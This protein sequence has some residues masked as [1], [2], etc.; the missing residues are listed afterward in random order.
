MSNA[1]RRP[2]HL[3]GP[4]HGDQRISALAERFKLSE[5]AAEQ[6]ARLFDLLATDET[7]PSAIRDRRRILDDHLADSLVAIEIDQ[8]SSARKAAD[9][10][11]G[12]GLPGLPLAIACPGMEMTLLE[13]SR[14]KCEFIARAI[15]ACRIAGASV[16]CERAESWR[17]GLGRMDLVTARAVGPLPVVIEYAAPLLSL[18][19]VLVAWR[20]R[21]EPEVEHAAGLAAGQLA[22][23]LHEARR[24]SPYPGARNR[25]LFVWQK[26]GDTPADFPRRP[27]V[28]LKRPLGSAPARGG[29]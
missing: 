23:E 10:G 22:L 29:R 3:P 4:S 26:V 1:D 9:L 14:R 19:G 7:A 8:V 27:G 15:A 2:S 25:H 12:A 18:G 24:V 11:A 6:L 28:A 20:G 17:G 13:S 5:T 16:A 21:R